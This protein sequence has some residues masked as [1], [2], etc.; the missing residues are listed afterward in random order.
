ML[1]HKCDS[2]KKTIPEGA[3]KIDV[4]T[5]WE[6]SSLCMTCGVP[7]MNFLRKAKLISAKTLVELKSR[8]AKTRNK[9]LRIGR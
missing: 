1:V 5:S 3:P 8:T 2:C 4:R 7:I 6:W 9:G